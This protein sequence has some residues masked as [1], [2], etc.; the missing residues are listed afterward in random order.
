MEQMEELNKKK[1]HHDT[2]QCV[3]SKTKEGIFN[4]KSLLKKQSQEIISNKIQRHKF[5]IKILLIGPIG[6]GKS[7]T[8]ERTTNN[9]FSEEKGSTCGIEKQYFKV[10]LNDHSNINYQYYDTPGQEKLYL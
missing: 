7:S 10:D 5:F 8:I 4:L 6:S 2:I 9:T 3:S 1:N